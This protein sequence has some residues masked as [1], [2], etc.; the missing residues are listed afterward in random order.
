MKSLIRK[1]RSNSTNGK[2]FRAALAVGAL[3]A[4]AKGGVAVKELI[5]ARAFGRSDALDAFLIAY[6]LP[7]FVVSNLVMG[8]LASAL[9]PVFVEIR[10]SEGKKATQRLFSNMLLL[11]TAA[12]IAVAV[13][14][15]LLAP[16]YLPYLASGFSPAKLQLTREVLYLLLPFVIFNGLSLFATA[17][18]NAEERF[19][20]PALVPLTTPVLTILFILA[21]PKAWGVFSLA[22]GLVAG[23]FSEALV[24]FRLTKARGFTLSWRWDRGDRSVGRVVAQ[25]MP[26]LGATFLSGGT[27]VVDQSMA[28]M[29]GSGSVAALNYANRI[30]APVVI[31]GATALSTAA[32]PYFSQLAAGGDLAGCKHTLKRYSALTLLVTTPVTLFLIAFSRP[33]TRL[34]FERGAFTSADTR[35]VSVVQMGYALQIPFYVCGMLFVRFLSSIKRNDVLMYGAAMNLLLDIILNLVLMRFWGV[36]GIA[37]STSLVYIFSFSYVTIWSIRLLSAQRTSV[38]PAGEA[39][40]AG[41]KPET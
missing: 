12:L 31:L 19:G 21:A 16:L 13:L 10:R 11:T 24:L 28:A 20:L 9:I 7:S 29:L 41:F 3:G 35:L 27:G 2:I 15:G 34:L 23:S 33:I 36:A 8:A 1:A 38:M 18:L 25:V 26:M 6:L 40:S 22:V 39:I 4:I 5:V 37:L 32:L 14:L 17:I 30:I